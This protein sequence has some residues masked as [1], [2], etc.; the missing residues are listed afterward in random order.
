MR[1]NKY[2]TRQDVKDAIEELEREC[3]WKQEALSTQLKL[4]TE[5][6]SPANLIKATLSDLTH[7]PRLGN[8]LLSTTLGLGVG[9]LTNKLLNR[10][11]VGIV[12]KVAGTALQLGVSTLVARKMPRWKFALKNI[13]SKKQGKPGEAA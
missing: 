1:S 9:Y 5:K 12:R 13:F 4:T 2:R 3:K 7:P 11:P 6:L 8:N 10:S